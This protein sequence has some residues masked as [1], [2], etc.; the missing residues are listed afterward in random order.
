[1]IKTYIK[2]L[3]FLTF[4]IQNTFSQK[5]MGIEEAIKIGLKNNIS[6][7]I[8]DA[9]IAKANAQTKAATSLPKTGVFIEN[10]DLRPS[11]SRGI[12][13]MGISQAIDFPTVYG[14]KR[15]YATEQAKYAGMQR[16]L[17]EAEL[18]RDIRHTYYQ[19]WYLWDKK[20]RYLQLDTLYAA[21]ANAA[22]LRQKTGESTGL[23]RIAAQAQHG[24]LKAQITQILRDIEVEQAE[25]KLL[26][27]YDFDIIPI[28]SFLL[29]MDTPLSISSNFDSKNEVLHPLL[30]LQKQQVTI[31]EAEK[32][33]QK[34]QNL[35]DFSGRFF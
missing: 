10:E 18:T 2:L 20:M 5:S 12:L 17:S 26:M 13:K 3:F 24:E 4:S 32:K 27:N 8:N 21:L 35:P 22:D 19:L 25:L 7:K 23:E 29:K 14:A 1:M 6:L 11:D 30:A 33:L 34:Q 31:A 15:Q 16:Q 28:S 9:H